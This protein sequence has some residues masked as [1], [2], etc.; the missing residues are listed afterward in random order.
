MEDHLPHGGLDGMV[1]AVLGFVYEQ[2]TTLG[3]G[4]RQRDS[5]EAHC[6]I[7]QASERDRTVSALQPYRDPSALLSAPASSKHRNALHFV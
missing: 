7:A 5:E 3:V 4:K 2:K 6:P 1:N